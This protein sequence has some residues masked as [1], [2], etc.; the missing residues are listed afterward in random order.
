MWKR[1]QVLWLDNIWFLLEI[2][3]IWELFPKRNWMGQPFLWVG[4]LNRV[5]LTCIECTVTVVKNA[6][7]TILHYNYIMINNK[8]SWY[9][10]FYHKHSLL[11]VHNVPY[12]II[13]PY[14]YSMFYHK[15]SLLQVQYVPYWTILHYR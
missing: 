11:Q 6:Y 12:Q 3:Q 15:H 1:A 13:L 7:W 2:D 10:M 14:W 8:P 9:S 4:F 5:G